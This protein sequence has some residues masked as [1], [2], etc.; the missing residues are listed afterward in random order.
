MSRCTS[1]P[2]APPVALKSAHQAS[3][4]YVSDLNPGIGRIRRGKTFA[5]I[6]PDGKPV[7]NER[8]LARIRSLVIPPA[9]TDVWICPHSTGHLQATGRDARGRKQYKYH[10]HWRETRD[11]TKYEKMV[12]FAKAL[13]RIRR[14]IQQDLAGS[15]LSRRRVLAAVVHLLETTLIRVG[16]DEYAR[17]NDSFGLTTL[18]DK[19][20]SV[21]G[22]GVHFTF[23]GKSGVRHEIKLDDPR[24]SRIVRDCRDLP[25]YELFQYVDDHGNVRDITSTDVNDYLRQ[26]AGDDFT[27]KDFRT[28]AGTILAA[29]AL[30]ECGPCTSERHG[31]RQVAAAIACVA[32]RLG[33]T[34]AVCRKCYVHPAILETYLDGSLH[35]LLKS[36]PRGRSIQNTKALRPEESAVLRLLMT[37]LPKSASRRKAA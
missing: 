19:H 25:G 13:P 33:N 12:P 30:L 32:Q 23:K 27:A 37:R 3:L 17:T 21:N 10:P 6:D 5:Y 26:I 20:A 28:W 24:V 4:C 11:Q 31:K 35:K 14:R 2:N 9:W 7:R 29:R 16:N 18:R 22:N 15:G 36:S 1:I 8:T 34:S